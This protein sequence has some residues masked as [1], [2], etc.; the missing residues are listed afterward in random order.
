M[1]DN[2]AENR[3]DAFERVPETAE[4]RSVSGRPTRA[5][6]LTYWQDRFGVPQST[7]E[8]ITFWEKGAGRI[9]AL[10]HELEGPIEIE[11]LG[12]PVLRTRQEFWKPTTDAARRFGTAASAN[13]IHLEEA[14]A[15]TFLAGE[16][17][18]LDWD[19]DWGYLLVARDAAGDPDIIGVGRYTY[20]TLAS[21]LPK[22]QRREFGEGEGISSR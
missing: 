7:F 5:E 9:W 21:M 16:D 3:S 8:G 10:S 13:V 14:A 15:R 11:A 22:G 4:D 17:L 18:D 6:I 12:L 2:A 1:S 20:G 19:G